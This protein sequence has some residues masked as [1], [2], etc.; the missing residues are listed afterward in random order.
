[1]GPTRGEQETKR[2][3]RSIFSFN[4]SDLSQG[5]ESGAEL[6][7]RWGGSIRPLGMSFE[8]DVSNI[9]RLCICY[10]SLVDSYQHLVLTSGVMN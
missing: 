7:N 5:P 1:M 8:K 9:N 4:E 3:V 6:R 10:Q 2:L